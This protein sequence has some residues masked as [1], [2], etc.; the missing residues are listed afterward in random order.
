MA[1]TAFQ[2]QY[3]QEYIHGF[4]D[5]QSILRATTVQEAVIKG[6]EAI[7]LVADSGAATAVNRGVNGLIPARADNNNQFTATL[8][9]WHDLVR[10]TNF[11]N[12]QPNSSRDFL[13]NAIQHWWR[14]SHRCHGATFS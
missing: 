7:F 13:G 9:E 2:R 11:N 6:N 14:W 1:A 10:K 3:R 4:E 5:R 12:H 8:L